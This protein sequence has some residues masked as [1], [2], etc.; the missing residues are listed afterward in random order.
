MFSFFLFTCGDEEGVSKKDENKFTTIY[1]NTL[2]FN[3]ARYSS[4]YYAEYMHIK[5]NFL[6]YYD[7]SNETTDD[8]NAGFFSCW[9][10]PLLDI[11]YKENQND[12]SVKVTKN[13]GE[14]LAV[15][16]V[17]NKDNTKWTLTFEVTGVLKDK[18]SISPSSESY[19]DFDLGP[20]FKVE[21]SEKPNTT[22]S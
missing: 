11:E 1:N 22:C 15:E 19:Y 7:K 10:I 20:Y 13:E 12:W 14:K 2:W 18:L 6:F 4:E 5:D 9:K 21:V 8:K 17:D 16:I 3:D